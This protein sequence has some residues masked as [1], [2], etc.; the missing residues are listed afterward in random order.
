M[1]VFQPPEQGPRQKPTPA[2]SDPAEPPPSSLPHTDPF[3]QLFVRV[4]CQISLPATPYPPGSGPAPPGPLRS[5]PTA[6]AVP[7]SRP[8]RCPQRCRSAPRAAPSPARSPSTAAPT[9]PPGAPHSPN[10]Q[11]LQVAQGAE[12]SILDAADL[13]VVQL[14]AER[15]GEGEGGQS[16]PER[17]R[18]SPRRCGA[19]WLCQR[20]TLRRSLA[21]LSKY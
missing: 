9:A 12:S 13:V 6:G 19:L 3:K 16:R 17:G 4:R 8:L 15:K 10:S 14:P 18:V 1:P 2:P 7:R 21:G 5:A 20:R 11:D